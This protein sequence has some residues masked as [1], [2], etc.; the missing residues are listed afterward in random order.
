M[1][2]NKI[3]KIINSIIAITQKFAYTVQKSNTFVALKSFIW[4]SRKVNATTMVWCFVAILSLITLFV[5]SENHTRAQQQLKTAQISLEEKENKISL[6]QDELATVKEDLKSAVSSNKELQQS[7]DDV[8]GELAAVNKTLNDLKSSEYKLVYMGKFKLTH[9]CVEKRK[10]ICGT[11]SGITATGTKVTAGRT[12]AVDPRSIPY[13]TQI[14]IEG[15]GWRIAEDCG[16][17]VKNN[18]IDIAVDAHSQAMT[19]GTKNGG[20]WVLVK[21]S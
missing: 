12:V 2:R 16:S 20:V 11:G 5:D 7:L 6:Y 18:H 4:K 3:H 15:Y 9:Y 8:S 19:M 17:A 10:H 14:Y 13:G 1:K 21:K